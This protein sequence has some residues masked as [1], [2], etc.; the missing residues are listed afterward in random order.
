MSQTSK[1]PGARDISD[2]KA[3]LGL[4]KSNTAAPGGAPVAAPPGAAPQP[5]APAGIVPPPG[6][7][8][9]GS[10]PAVPGGAPPP[11]I[12]HTQQAHVPDASSDPFGAMSAMAQNAAV[13]AAPQIVVVNDGSNVES[14][15]KKNSAAAIGRTVAMILLPLVAGIVMGKIGSGANQYNQVIADAKPIMEDVKVVRGGLTEMAAV[16]ERGKQTGKFIP[17]DDALTKSLASLEAVVTNDELVYESSLYH[18]ESNVSREIYTFYSDIH[19]LN[20]MLKDH[21]REAKKE[22]KILKEG[23]AKYKG[24]NPMAYGA[25]LQIP[26]AEESAA[27]ASVTMRMVQL[28]GPVCEGETKPN[29]KGCDG[30]PFTGF[31][32][33]DDETGGWKVNKIPVP[34]AKAVPGDSVVMLDPTSKS[35]KQIITG[36]QATLAEIAYGK[37]I[38]A[39]DAKVTQL[40]DTGKTIQNVLNEKS[41][42]STKFNFFL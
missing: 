2:L 41:N 40:L 18:L 27:G 28:G 34:G 31:A 36:G 19:T 8:I 7:N 37:R 30:Q 1:R 22:S 15:A 26:P 35:I 13:G 4:K 42:E 38:D 21:L 24:F 6:T 9:Q 17:G 12:A 5:P 3:R 11:G 39:I 32:H 33:R 16:L 25:L 23:A 14:V 10:I 20:A 29:P